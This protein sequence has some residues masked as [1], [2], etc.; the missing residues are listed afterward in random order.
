M[1]DTARLK[2]SSIAH[3]TRLP[4]SA[5]LPLL[6]IIVAHA[7]YA[8]HSAAMYDE[9]KSMTVEGTV[10][11][12]VW[13][14][15]HVYIYVEQ[16]QDQQ[17]IEWEVEGGPPSI[18]RRLGWASDT[19]K[20]GER[21]TVVGWPA[22]N[23]A[24]RVLRPTAIKHNGSVLFSR[25]TVVT[26][27]SSADGVASR[28]AEGLNGVWL[29]VYDKAVDDRLDADKLTLTA[30]GRAAYK[31]FDEKKMHPSARCVAYTAPFFMITPDL[32]RITQNG[33]VMLI[34]GEFD[35]AQRTVYLDQPTH[36]GAPASN[37]GHSIGHWEGKSLVIDTTRFSKN[38]VGNAYGLPSGPRKHLIERLTPSADGKSSTYHFELSDPE[39]MSAP[40][41]GDVQWLYRPD[42]AYAPEHCNP[43]IARHYTQDK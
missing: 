5:V 37:Q 25:D 26:Q 35:G 11:R 34:D 33:K 3:A 15:P 42:T 23:P 14:N 32:K 24:R 1:K 13:A 8:H 18:M 21:I 43:E 6:L 36:E 9:K 27:L 28:P 17:R 41:G 39:F 22:K 12:Y 7:S 20:A 10:T 38:A 31:H 4:L 30:A 40:V 29:T 19:L 16:Q 2:R